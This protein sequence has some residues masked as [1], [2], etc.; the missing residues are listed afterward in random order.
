MQTRDDDYKY[1]FYGSLPK[2]DPEVL[3]KSNIYP[4]IIKEYNPSD[5]PETFDGRFVWALYI[6]TASN[7]F[8]E[9]SWALV[10]KDILN[11]R[12]AIASGG[13]IIFNLDYFEILACINHSPIQKKEGV[14]SSTSLD[15]SNACQGYSIYDAWEH[16]YKFGLCQVNCFSYKKLKKL[17]KT[18]DT[19]IDQGIKNYIK[20]F[21]NYGLNPVKES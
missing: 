3:A 4:H 5:I 17:D 1:K 6:Q 12:F 8:A 20:N 2:D 11:D 13:Q 10:A 9:S 7:Q 15:Y 14:L 21:M 18:A 16:M 19:L